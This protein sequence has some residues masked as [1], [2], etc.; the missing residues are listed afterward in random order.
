VPSGRR[1]PAPEIAQPKGG[2]KRASC[3]RSNVCFRIGPWP[4]RF[5]TAA[6]AQPLA[7]P[8]PLAAVPGTAAL[9]RFRRTLG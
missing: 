7:V 9:L 8:V 5:G 3:V 1:H 4:R 6:V 2:G